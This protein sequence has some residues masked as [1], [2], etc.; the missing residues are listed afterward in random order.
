[1]AQAGKRR[2]SPSRMCLIFLAGYAVFGAAIIAMV[3][4]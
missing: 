2:M 4:T 1:M 3:M